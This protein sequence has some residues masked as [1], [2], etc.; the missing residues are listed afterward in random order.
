MS[1]ATT[2]PA[3]STTTTAAAEVP[4][5]TSGVPLTETHA[6]SSPKTPQPTPTSSATPTSPTTDATSPPAAS[7]AEMSLQAHLG[8]KA[9]SAS[10]NTGSTSTPSS[11][12][13]VT[14]EQQP[15]KKGKK[16]QMTPE[17]RAKLE[18]MEAAKEAARVERLKT[19]EKKL[20]E[21]IRPFV[22][23]KNP[24][25][26]ADEET[27]RFE[28]AQRKEADD[29]KLESFGIEVSLSCLG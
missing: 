21:R 2:E 17:Q 14:S 28:E 3:A 22:E 12:T 11:G 18:A 26:K 15:T 4:T 20:L 7:L 16:P 24:G 1:G 27:K 19:L 23:A 10:T 5:S 8:D 6:G 13:T 29:L 9:P 25:D